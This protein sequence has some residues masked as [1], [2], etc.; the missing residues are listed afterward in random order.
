[1]CQKNKYLLYYYNS[2]IKHMKKICIITIA[3]LIFISCGIFK[4]TSQNGCPPSA[5]NLGAE[6]IMMYQ[7]DGYTPKTAKEKKEYELAKKE[8]K[9]NNKPIVKEAVNTKD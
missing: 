3:S 5:K 7:Q 1:M 4:K 8:L 9:S 6:K 2:Q